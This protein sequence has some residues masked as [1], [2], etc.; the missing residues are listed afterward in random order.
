MAG[1]DFGYVG[2]G[3]GKVHIYRGH[4]AVMLNVPE[5]AAVERLLE[6]IGS[7]QARR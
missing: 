5:E 7:D 6:L 4:T 1:A 3:E 2:A